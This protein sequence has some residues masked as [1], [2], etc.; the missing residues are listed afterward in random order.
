[1]ACEMHEQDNPLANAPLGNKTGLFRHWKVRNGVPMRLSV[2]SDQSSKSLIDKGFQP[3]GRFEH[4][5][6]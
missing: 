1:M 5:G 6:I 2:E 4:V 3:I